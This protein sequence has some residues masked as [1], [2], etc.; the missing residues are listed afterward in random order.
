MF[1]EIK[2]TAL[3]LPYSSPLIRVYGDIRMITRAANPRGAFD[4]ASKVNKT[5][6]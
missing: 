6:A 2:T 3:K 1:K 5:K 4:N